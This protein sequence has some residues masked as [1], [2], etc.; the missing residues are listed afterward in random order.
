MTKAKLLEGAKAAC[1]KMKVGQEAVAALQ[2]VQRGN[3]K[4]RESAGAGAAVAES[5]EGSKVR[6]LCANKLGLLWMPRH[7]TP[8]LRALTTTTALLATH[9]AP[10]S[11]VRDG[12]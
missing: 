5:G 1:K 4:G 6:P 7:S 12:S 11:M 8:C 9:E 10:A 2:H 3:K